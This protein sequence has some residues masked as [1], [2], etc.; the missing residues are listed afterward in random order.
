MTLSGDGQVACDS[1]TLYGTKPEFISGIMAQ[2]GVGGHSHS[3]NMKHISEQ[4]VC[5]G[6]KLAIKTVRKTQVWE[7]KAY[8]DFG[9]NKG[10]QKEDGKYSRM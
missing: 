9:Q 7:L 2:K 5:H 10:M 3:G 8:Y 4:E 6:P 1:S